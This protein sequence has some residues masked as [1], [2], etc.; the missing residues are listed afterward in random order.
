MLFSQELKKGLLK[1]KHHSLSE[2]QITR[3]ERGSTINTNFNIAVV[4]KTNPAS[5]TIGNR[6]NN[7][8]MQFEQVQTGI[9]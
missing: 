6:N 3:G 2:K 1:L 7:V 8:M 5:L 4:R 9:Q